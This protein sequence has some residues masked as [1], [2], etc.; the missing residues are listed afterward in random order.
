M[1]D[2]ISKI[3]SFRDLNIN[4]SDD[5]IQKAKKLSEMFSEAKSI[6]AYPTYRN[7]IIFE[8]DDNNQLLEFE[9]GETTET[10]TNKTKTIIKAS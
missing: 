8:I 4:I 10:L 9:I 5:V 2:I 7:T 6:F 3:D 1:D